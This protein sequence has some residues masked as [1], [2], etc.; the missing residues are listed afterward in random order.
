MAILYAQRQ[1]FYKSKE[2][3]LCREQFHHINACRI[4]DVEFGI[5]VSGKI[6]YQCIDHI[7][8][9]KWSWE[10]RLDFDNLQSIC[11]FCNK[12]KLNHTGKFL[13]L[14]IRKKAHFNHGLATF[15]DIDKLIDRMRQ[16]DRI[17]K[18]RDAYSDT[19]SLN[20]VNWLN[21]YH[22]KCIINYA[23]KQW[24]E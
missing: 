22:K 15:D 19:L 17:D 20:E 23:I 10:R 16:Q 12:E 9:L 14:L 13:P 1:K 7:F 6:Y 5:E 2:W 21:N 4:C 3:K 24:L 11:N 18:G 8:P